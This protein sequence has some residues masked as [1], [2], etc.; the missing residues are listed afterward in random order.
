MHVIGIEKDMMEINRKIAE[1]NRSLFR[2]E[3]V[4][5]LNIM[6]AVGSG[7]TSLIEVLY[8]KF[9]GFRVGVIAGDVISDIDAKRLE[10][11]GIPV[12]GV[13]TG[14][15][16]H[17]DAHLIQHS[18]DKIPLKEIDLL[19]IEN[20]GNLICPVDFPLGAQRSV[21]M[22]SV[23]EGDDTVEKHP[24]IFLNSDAAVINKIDIA[25]S[26]GAD[27]VKMR[28]DALEINPKLRVFMTSVKTGDGIP[29]LAEWIWN[30]KRK[31]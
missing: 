12:I 6:G 14:R 21:T 25:E 13:N 28:D 23:S 30:E 15:E 18:L 3:G 4:F 24:M 11:L 5:A 7:K 26:V 16:C 2:K 20:V 10:K 8:E 29:E 27:P 9:K 17:L 22:V 31:G 1:A 19:F